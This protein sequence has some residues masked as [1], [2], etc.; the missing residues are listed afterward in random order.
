MKRIILALACAVLMPLSLMALSPTRTIMLYPDG[1]PDSNGYAPS[2]EYVKDG[3]KIFQTSEPRIDLYCAEQPKGLLLICPG[4][5]YLFTS[6]G[7]E[8]KNVA[9]FFVPRGYTIAVLKYRLPNGHTNIPLE[10]A[11]RA[12]EILRDSAEAWQL[13]STRIGVMGFSAGGHLASSLLTKYTNPKVRPD[14][15]ILVY[16]VISMDSTLTHQT[17]CEELLGKNPSDEQRRLWST[18]LQVTADTPPCLIVGCQDDTS[19]KIENSIRFYQAL[20]AAHVPASL[21]IVPVGRH[22][23]GFERHFPQR[24]LIDQAILNFLEQR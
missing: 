16:P 9:E 2:D 12:M 1:A 18:D 13:P 24:E 3:P 14:Y 15:G 4:G 22:G 5:A 11:C 10:D 8:G 6:V 20:T 17:S 21:V 7:N 19:V 23:W